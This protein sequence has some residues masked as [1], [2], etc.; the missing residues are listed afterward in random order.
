MCLLWY[1]DVAGAQISASDDTVSIWQER[2][3]ERIFEYSTRD[4]DNSALVEEVARFAEDPLDI[5]M[6]SAEELCSIPGIT[7]TLAYRI[8][9]RRARSIFRS[10]DDLLTVDG[11]TPRLLLS[12]RR[13]LTVKVQENDIAVTG[14]LRSRTSSELEDRKGYRD[15]SYPGSSLKVYNLV[16]ASVRRPASASSDIVS[17]CEIGAVTKKDPGEKNVAD[18]A[19]GYLQLHARSLGTSIVVG[20]YTVEAA[21]GLIFWR[22]S[23]F[24]KGG[25]VIGP[26]R[27]NGGG[28]RPYL[29]TDENRFLRGLGVTV[30]MDDIQICGVYSNKTINANID[31]LRRITGIDQSGLFRTE[32][33]MRRKNSTRIIVTGCRA[34]VHLIKGLKIGATAYK[35]RFA[36]PFLTEFGHDTIGLREQWMQGIDISYTNRT[37][38]LF[39]ECALGRGNDLAVIGGAGFAPVDE[40]GLSVVLRKYPARFQSLYGFAFAENAGSGE[41]EEGLY[42][43]VQV[44][45]LP[46]CIVAG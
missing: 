41:N 37:L 22:P 29:S 35:A 23:A 46:D 33:E 4:A 9:D 10:V 15:G 44:Q 17:A 3:W 39:C 16:R 38:D 30:R 40:I 34:A 18:F 32:T 28:I 43:G 2:E 11:V 24:A 5:N 1:A 14:L 36:N 13:L 42:A 12:I 7:S 21:E 6:A 45:P 27:K 19:A 8:I 26:A 31:S 25:D 20:D